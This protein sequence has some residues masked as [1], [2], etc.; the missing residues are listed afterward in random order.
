V[1]HRLPARRPPRV[2]PDQPL[3]RIPAGEVIEQDVEESAA[4]VHP[5][6][7]VEEH[8]RPGVRVGP[9][10]CQDRLTR[11]VVLPQSSRWR[12]RR[13]WFVF[14]ELLVEAAQ[15]LGPLGMRGDQVEVS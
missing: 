9:S 6:R 7:V 10:V 1:A 12:V 2:E 15:G 14:G 4:T 5:V 8:D 13:V 11:V 3:Q